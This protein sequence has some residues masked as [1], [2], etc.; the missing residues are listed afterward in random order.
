MSQDRDERS[1]T[2]EAA[3]ARAVEI[4]R[5]HEASAT[6]GSRALVDRVVAAA[7]AERASEVA[8]GAADARVVPM[9]RAVPPLVVRAP[10]RR[11][12]AFEVAA[13]LA[14]SL[15]AGIY[16]GGLSGSL[17]TALDVASAFGIEPAGS[18]VFPLLAG[19]DTAA[20]QL[21]DAL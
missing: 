2:D 11:R 20:D 10:I 8:S 3:L 16:V 15:V 5:R 6:A 4:A 18:E 12:A 7:V 14:A 1:R 19:D 13:L 17:S 21:E 9:R